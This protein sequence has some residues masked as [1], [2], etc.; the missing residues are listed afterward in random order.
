MVDKNVTAEPRYEN[1]R[2]VHK[3][4]DRN[5]YVV[6]WREKR[7]SEKKFPRTCV[8]KLEEKLLSRVIKFSIR[9]LFPALHIVTENN[10]END[11]CDIT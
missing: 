1:I 11:I 5:F 8:G 9:I 10:D 2:D 6:P 3:T 4:C 7:I